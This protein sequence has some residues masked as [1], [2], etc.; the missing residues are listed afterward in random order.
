VWR[1]DFVPLAQLAEHWSYE[2]KV[3]VS[4]MFRLMF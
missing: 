1:S 4:Y 3:M 2:P